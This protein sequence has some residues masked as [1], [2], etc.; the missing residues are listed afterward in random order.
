MARPEAEHPSVGHGVKIVE[1]PYSGEVGTRVERL[2]IPLSKELAI[3]LLSHDIV[4]AGS[5]NRLGATR[6]LV[7]PYPGDPRKAWFIL[8]DGE[9]MVL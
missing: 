3:V 5:S 9:E 6:E 4:K 2:A 7:W 1:T 8:H